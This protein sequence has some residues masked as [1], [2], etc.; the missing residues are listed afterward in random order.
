MVTARGTNEAGTRERKFTAATLAG[1]PETPELSGKMSGADLVVV[2]APSAM[3]EAN[4]DYYYLQC[5]IGNKP[6]SKLVP[7]DLAHIPYG[8]IKVPAVKG[9]DTWCYSALI[10]MG[11]T[12]QFTSDFG[13]VKVSKA[14]KVTA[15]KLS[16]SAIADGAKKGL[17]SVKWT[18]KDSLGK[19]ITVTV[20]PS[21]K[22]CAKKSALSCLV[23]GLPSGA[24][25]VVR[26]TARGQSGSRSIWKTVIVK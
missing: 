7:A 21:K 20:N 11:A 13:S 5:T 12:K 8:T 17:I 25:I 2:V 6:W 9:K 4:V 15:G 14:G 3:D 24:Q 26:I 22:S 16:L 23:A 10:A 18:A 1:V 19:N